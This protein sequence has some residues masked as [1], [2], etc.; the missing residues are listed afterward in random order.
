VIFKLIGKGVCFADKDARPI[1][2]GLLHALLRF[3]IRPINQVVYLGSSGDCS[4]GDLILGQVSR[5]DAF[6]GYPCRTRLPSC[7]TG[8]TTGTPEVR[9]SRSSRTRDSPLQVS[10]AH[11]R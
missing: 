5:L 6:S 10:Y 9:P 7:A 11:S 1:S 4:R 3:H 8:V 2:T